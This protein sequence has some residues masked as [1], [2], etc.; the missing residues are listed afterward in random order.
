MREMQCVTYI[1][2]GT[3][4]VFIS[5][6]YCYVEL[7]YKGTLKK[8]NLKIKFRKFY[9]NS[10]TEYYSQYILQSSRTNMQKKKTMLIREPNMFFD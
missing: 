6:V 4:V 9:D 5:C 1:L 3:I 10:Y 7:W 8:K 2:C